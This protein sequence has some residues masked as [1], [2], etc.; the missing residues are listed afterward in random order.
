LQLG[1]LGGRTGAEVQGHDWEYLLGTLGWLRFDR[2]IGLGAHRIG[3]LM[4]IGA[5]IWGALYLVK[6]VDETQRSEVD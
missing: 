4:M 3:L 6:N 5:L 1:L 2:S